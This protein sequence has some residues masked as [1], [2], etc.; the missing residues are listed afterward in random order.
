MGLM[1]WLWEHHQ[2][3]M[4]QCFSLPFAFLFYFLAKCG[5]LSLANRYV[6]RLILLH[7]SIHLLLRLILHSG[8]QGWLEPFH[9]TLGRRQNTPQT[10]CQFIFTHIN[11][12]WQSRVAMFS[13]S[14]YLYMCV[15]GCV[16][17]VVTMG[18]Y[19]VLLFTPTLVF[20]VLVHCVDHGYIHAWVFGFQMLW[21]T[22]W[23]LLLQY[24]EYYLQEAVCIR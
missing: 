5:Y 17:A 14:R 15:G 18:V 11:T 9:P 21:Q 20:S 12:Y 1:D 6:Y 4:H 24:R 7:P 8:L 3:L 2:F 19:S 16:L 23:H 13:L 22:T 10:S